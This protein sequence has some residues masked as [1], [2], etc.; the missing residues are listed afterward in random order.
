REC[1]DRVKLIALPGNQGPTK[2]RIE[3]VLPPNSDCQRFVRLCRER[4][5]GARQPRR[6]RPNAF[7]RSAREK[8]VR[9]SIFD[10]VRI[11]NRVHVIEPDDAIEIVYASDPP[12][13]DVWLDHMSEAN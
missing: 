6:F 4:I 7:S 9:Q 11:R 13:D 10:F 1:I 3:K 2:V 12:V 5:F 8:A